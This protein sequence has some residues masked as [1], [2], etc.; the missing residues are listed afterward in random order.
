MRL[1]RGK[2]GLVRQFLAANAPP[3]FEGEKEGGGKMPAIHGALQPKRRG[4]RKISLFLCKNNG[5]PLHIHE[6]AAG[7]GKTRGSNV[8]AR[9]GTNIH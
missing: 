2:K 9:N 6:A 5:R 3:L 1:Y 4:R 7:V 8:R